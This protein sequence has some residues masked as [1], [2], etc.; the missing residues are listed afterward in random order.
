MFLG[1]E[2]GFSIQFLMKGS[3]VPEAEA[4]QGLLCSS[5]STNALK[6]IL[7]LIFHTSA[8]RTEQQMRHMNKGRG[9]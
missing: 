2:D 7:M 9:K 5:G 1:E 4:A 8:G 3:S 6:V